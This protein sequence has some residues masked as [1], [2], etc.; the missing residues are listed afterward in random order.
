MLELLQNCFD[1]LD[2]DE[3]EELVP[4]VQS[5]FQMVFADLQA[6]TIGNPIEHHLVVLRNMMEIAKAQGYSRVELK[7]AAALAILHDIS[8]VEKITTQQVE[9]LR[10]THP[11]RAQAQE[12][13]RQQNRVLHMIEG[14]AMAHRRLLQ[15]NDC[16]GKVAFGA[17]DIR[18]ICDVIR[19]HDIPSLD[20]PIPRENELAVAFREAD[21]LWMVHPLGIRTDLRRK[22]R[23]PDDCQACLKQLEDNIERFRQERMLYRGMEANE[24]PF[25]DEETFF[26]TSGGHKL[27]ARL[28]TEG[29]EHYGKRG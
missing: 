4:I 14:S 1:P 29:K 3:R 24:G 23:D 9:E 26:R 11:G 6:A 21:R 25:C 12:L 18:A 17:E 13:R 22:A 27:F 28:Y 2:Q 7:R 15:L 8:A 20:L 5:V 10:K 16:L 19:I